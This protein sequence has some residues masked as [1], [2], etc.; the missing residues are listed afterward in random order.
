TQIVAV[1]GGEVVG[2]CRLLFEPPDCRL[3]RMAVAEQ[4]RGGGA[5]SL[6]VAASI[7]AARKAG[8][9]RI[10]LHAQRRAEAFYAGCGFEPVGETFTEEGIPHVLMRRSVV[11]GLP[12]R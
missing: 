2:T 7:K 11:E 9:E 5:G 4:A 3:G 10:V 1:D 6:L 8:C 12:S